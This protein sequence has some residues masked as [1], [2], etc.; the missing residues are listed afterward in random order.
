MKIDAKIPGFKELVLFV[1][2][3]IALVFVLVFSVRVGFLAYD[4]FYGGGVSYSFLDEAKYSIRGALSGGGFLGV[5]VWIL[6]RR[7]YKKE[8]GE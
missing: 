5:S 3:N 1:L 8:N 4:D 2:I 6:S 7:H